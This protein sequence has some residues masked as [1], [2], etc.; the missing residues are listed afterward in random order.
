MEQ[1]PLLCIIHKLLPHGL[2]NGLIGIRFSLFGNSSQW[3][4]WQHFRL[5]VT[6]ITSPFRLRQC[7]AISLR[8]ACKM[9]R[10]SRG[11]DVV[12]IESQLG[13]TETTQQIMHLLLHPPLQL[14]LI[15]QNHL[16]PRHKQIEINLIHKRHETLCRNQLAHK[17]SQPNCLQKNRLN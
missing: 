8:R 7:L 16:P 10:R 5:E 6:F 3:V 13:Q 15:H 17:V 11:I 9:E 2:R 14:A 4:I 1:I 12:K